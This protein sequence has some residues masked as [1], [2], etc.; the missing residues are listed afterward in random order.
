MNRRSPYYVFVRP[1]LAALA[2]AVG[3]SLA[4]P[5]GAPP[6]LVAMEPAAACSAPVLTGSVESTVA[7]ASI[8]DEA[9]CKCFDRHGKPRECT[10]TEEY[11]CCRAAA[12][13]LFEQCREA[14][15]SYLG[16]DFERGINMMACNLS[17][18]L[19]PF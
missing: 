3:A 5:V 17:F 18:V 6:V 8:Q 19:W 7:A 11:R 2:V 12:Q 15:G 13:D 4:V 16:C 1:V 9:G 14:G 10:H